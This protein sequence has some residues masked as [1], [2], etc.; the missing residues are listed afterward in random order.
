MDLENDF[1]QLSE[2]SQP[3]TVSVLAPLRER[4]KEAGQLTCCCSG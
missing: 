2:P 1:S 3:I 4:R